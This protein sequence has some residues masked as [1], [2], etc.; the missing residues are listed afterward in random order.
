MEKVGG[1]GSPEQFALNAQGLGFAPPGADGKSRW[2]HQPAI[3]GG[4]KRMWLWGGNDQDVQNADR[5]LIGIKALFKARALL[6]SARGLTSFPVGITG[7]LVDAPIPAQ[8]IRNGGLKMTITLSCD[9]FVEPGVVL[10]AAHE[11]NS[12]VSADELIGQSGGAALSAANPSLL[13]NPSTTYIFVGLTALQSSAEGWNRKAKLQMIATATNDSARISRGGQSLELTFPPVPDYNPS[14][15]EVIQVAIPGAMVRSGRATV[16]PIDHAA[17]RVQADRADCEVSEWESW[18]VCSRVCR[19]GTQH[20]SRSV[21]STNRGQGSECPPTYEERICNTCDPC[22]GVECQNGG[23]C[24]FG[25]CICPPGYSG[26]DCTAPP[27]ILEPFW[28]TDDWSQ[29]TSTC[30]GGLQTRVATCMYVEKSGLTTAVP[31]EEM[32]PLL[33]TYEK[34]VQ[35]NPDEDPL[36]LR[37][38]SNSMDRTRL[39]EP[40]GM[41]LTERPC[42]PQDCDDAIVT[43]VMNVGDSPDQE[44]S[45]NMRR[46]RLLLWGSDD[47]MMSTVGA[48]VDYARSEA[49][50]AAVHSEL[51]SS[52]GLDDLQATVQQVGS[53]VNDASDAIDEVSNLVGQASSIWDSFSG[54]VSAWGRQ[55]RSRRISTSGQANRLGGSITMRLYSPGAALK[56]AQGLKTRGDVAAAIGLSRATANR[57]PSL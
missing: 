53:F 4:T 49:A 45:E 11:T 28:V 24:A 48:V 25:Q 13:T 16:V 55:R 17:I 34:M 26:S 40:A 19:P 12:K 35:E 5:F 56:Q 52:L 29:C 37:V 18:S 46:R 44:S 38:V 8:S 14:G 15:D 32:K 47:D 23:L 6:V 43:V 27:P 21:L 31:E 20:R 57:Y 41:P 50:Q 39:C 9:L 10:Q 33:A 36:S 7:P 2:E 51:V 42:N 1:S 3:A 22:S 54:F 30:G